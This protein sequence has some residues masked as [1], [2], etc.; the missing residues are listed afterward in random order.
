MGSEYSFKFANH[1]NLDVFFTLELRPV[2]KS[3]T[4]L[5]D[6]ARIR[7]KMNENMYKNWRNCGGRGNGLSP[8]LV[9][10]SIDMTKPNASID[11][12]YLKDGQAEDISVKFCFTDAD[13]ISRIYKYDLIERDANGNITGGLR[14]SIQS[15]TLDSRIT[16]QSIIN[17]QNTD[18]GV[19][20]KVEPDKFETVNW[21][22]G[23]GTMIDGQESIEGSYTQ[24]SVIYDVCCI[25]PDGSFAKGSIDLSS[26]FGISSITKNGSEI[27]INLNKP[28][29]DN[30]WIIVRPVSSAGI[31]I[32]NASSG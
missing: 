21:I 20:L 19:E 8:R 23:D 27:K 18:Y 14:F 1:E 9:F 2:E 5:L 12:L 10:K 3:D 7:V 24:N 32:N 15:P 30:S 16:P 11:N 26:V 17:S 6:I 4:L 29:I 22:V 13:S 31:L 25:T 28:A